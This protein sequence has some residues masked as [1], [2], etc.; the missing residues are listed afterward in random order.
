MRN[1]ALFAILI[2]ATSIIS[3]AQTRNNM[4]AKTEYIEIAKFKLKDGCT[5]K[6]FLDAEI[7]VRAGLI[8]S[9]KGFIS[10]EISKDTDGNWLMDMRFETKEEMDAWMV[11]LKQDPNMKV[12]GSM[13]DFQSMRMEF[14]TKQL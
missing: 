11:A 5:D 3:M 8:K 1:L 9:Q 10:R 2:V 6:Q 7:A 4:N 13:I 12:F 14:F